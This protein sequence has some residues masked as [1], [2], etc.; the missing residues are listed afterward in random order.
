MDFDPELCS[1]RRDPLE[2]D[3]KN[4]KTLKKLY[5]IDNNHEYV[6]KNVLYS[7]RG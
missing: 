3:L 6:N 1:H 2:L 5:L 4:L 7:D